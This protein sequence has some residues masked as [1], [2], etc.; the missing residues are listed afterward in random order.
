MGT[1]MGAWALSAWFSLTGL[2]QACGPMTGP[3]DFESLRATID[4]CGITSVEQLVEVLPQAYRTN[5]TL[6]H[7]SRSLQGASVEYPR[8]IAFGENAGTLLAFNGHPSQS[9]YDSVEVTEFKPADG[10][11]EYREIV[12]PEGAPGGRVAYSEK[13]PALCLSCHGIKPRPIW[14]SYFF[15]PGVYGSVDDLTYDIDHGGA[16]VLE[17]ETPERQAYLSF[18]QNQKTQ[19]RYAKLE[20]LWGD[21][22]A[23]AG[24][25]NEALGLK[26]VE[27]GYKRGMRKLVENPAILPFRYALMGASICGR[28][29]G[30][31]VDELIPV[32]V[33]QR[34]GFPDRDRLI[35]DTR[36]IRERSFQEKFARFDALWP[37]SP[38]PGRL[39][40][41]V[42]HDPDAM[43]FS[44]DMEIA[45]VRYI[46][47]TLG[48][49]YLDWD[50]GLGRNGYEFDQGYNE[51]IR[52]AVQIQEALVASGLDPWLKDVVIYGGANYEASRHKPPTL[53][54]TLKEKSLEALSR[55]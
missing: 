8:V 11:Y 36:A 4:S 27:Q 49:S 38:L 51:T 9:R 34:Y 54:Q 44:F 50:F 15:W 3:I 30:Y 48:V 21:F 55:L 18:L 20:K 29:A 13:N 14:D 45:Q 43:R 28:D 46:L 2:Q 42:A 6:V 12:F 26:L 22:Y 17:P 19:G 24:G 33:R 37:G 39:A 47:E 7:A 52:G 23:R 41:R 53:C 32:E 25:P 40:G 5:Y 16:G 35:E 10:S 1:T 31:R